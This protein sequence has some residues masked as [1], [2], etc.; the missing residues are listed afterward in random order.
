MTNFEISEQ[1]CNKYEAQSDG[2][3][4]D[5]WANI[6]Q[7][8][9][10]LDGSKVCQGFVSFCLNCKRDHHDGGAENCICRTDRN[11]DTV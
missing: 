8:V 1:P 2:N 6:Y 4:H 3:Q 7:C 11:N 5:I 10:P 9:C